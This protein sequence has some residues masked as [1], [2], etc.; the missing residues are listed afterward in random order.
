MYEGQEVQAERLSSWQVALT[1]PWQP[2]PRD[3]RQ[4]DAS[5]NTASCLTANFKLPRR[6]C[7][8][9]FSIGREC[10]EEAVW[11]AFAF[12][13][14]IPLRTWAG[15]GETPLSIIGSRTL[16]GPDTLSSALTAP[17]FK[18]GGGRPG[19]E[20]GVGWR[21]LRSVSVVPPPPILL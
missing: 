7:P 11:L 8:S 13:S 3:P 17:G 9:P 5:L 14:S 21:N 2:P 19:V 16:V 12:T 1:A 6:V 4:T 18:R 10:K 20:Q 15:P